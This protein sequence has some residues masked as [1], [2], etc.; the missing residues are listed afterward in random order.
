MGGFLMV[1]FILVVPR[2]EL[3]EGSGCPWPWSG[4][5]KLAHDA[6]C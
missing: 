2:G 1:K 5:N 6:A 4:C 3:V